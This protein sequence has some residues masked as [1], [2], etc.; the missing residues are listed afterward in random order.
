ISAIAKDALQGLSSS[1]KYL[2]S[3]YFYDDAG[4]AIFQDIMR[5]PE[6]YLTDC[7]HEIFTTFRH[8]IIHLFK[9]GVMAFDLI[10]LG[11]GDVMK[12]K[13]LLQAIMQQTVRLNYNAADS[14][15]K[16]N[17][18]LVSSLKREMPFLNDDAS[19]D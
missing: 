13:V 12:T 6:Y 11:S 14:S 10:E 4:S 9:E 5:M 1:P 15:H 2:L 3:K 19:I 8:S 18:E 16:E 7:E 17:N